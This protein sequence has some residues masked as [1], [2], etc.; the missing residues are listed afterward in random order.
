MSLDG[1]RLDDTRLLDDAHLDAVA[2]YL[3]ER[4]GLS[5]SGARRAHLLRQI[6][7]AMEE[8]GA[9]SAS[10]Y[11]SRLDTDPEQFDDLV[12]RVT[13]GES[14]FFRDPAQLAIFREVVVPERLE[15][16]R[17]G[18]RLRIW[19][20]GCAIGQEPYTLAMVLEEEGQ[21]ESA[22][23]VATDI[24]AEA[25]RVARA[26]V[27][28]RWS[29]RA[30]SDRQRADH[31]EEMAMGHRV[32]PRFLARVDFR[33]HNLLD[34]DPSLSSMDVIFCRNVL[35]YFDAAGQD[36]AAETLAGALAPGGWLITGS[37]DPPL[38]H[39]EELEPHRTTAGVVYRRSSAPST[40]PRRAPWSRATGAGTSRRAM[41][42]HTLS[43]RRTGTSGT[44]PVRRAPTVPADVPASPS[45]TDDVEA[46]LATIRAFGGSGALEAA[47]DA[48]AAAIGDLPLRPELRV[49]EAVVLLEAGRPLDAAAS[50]RAALYLDDQLAMAHLVCAR[51]E[52]ALGRAPAARR[53]LH[54]AR[55]LLEAVP[56]ESIVP[57]SDGEPAG[58]L[59]AMVTTHDEALVGADPGRNGW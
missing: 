6:A 9:R 8:S 14:Y 57:L 30:V 40:P 31:F 49:L 51:A 37:S 52:A 50:A 11:C 4:M 46:L 22:R 54:R 16:H 23:I 58:R 1:M 35:I 12:R 2:A 43:R 3:T 21:A 25:L 56:A 10:S 28:G 44:A 13:V 33:R 18:S 38:S 53:S 55:S 36:R 48:A 29:L 5:A 39:I 26:G 42:G 59:L 47:L 27:Y 20:A 7:V 17:D 15:A 41:A 34:S 24:S 19:S 32:H 45:T